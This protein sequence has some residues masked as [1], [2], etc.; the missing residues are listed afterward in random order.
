MAATT[1]HLPQQNDGTV[2]GHR[3]FLCQPNRGLFV[4]IARCRTR[5]GYSVADG[6]HVS[7]PSRTLGKKANGEGWNTNLT[8][9]NTPYATAAHNVRNGSA[10]PYL[11]DVCRRDGTGLASSTTRQPHRERSADPRLN[12]A[13]WVPIE[14]SETHCRG[15]RRW[16]INAA[17][18]HD[19]QLESDS[20][21]SSSS[22]SA[23]SES[24]GSQVVNKCLVLLCSSS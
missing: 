6:R 9:Q 15:S 14:S 11:S 5:A 16:E 17:R 12:A 2:D 7:F 3:Y 22:E 13:Q 19:V 1:T 20:S 18:R 23:S 24:D 4:R 21:E 10:P 8:N